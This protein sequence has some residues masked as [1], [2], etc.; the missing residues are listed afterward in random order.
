MKMREK[1]RLAEKTIEDMYEALDSACHRIYLLYRE[2]KVTDKV[3]TRAEDLDIW[4]KEARLGMKAYERWAEAN[5][6]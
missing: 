4:Y 1:L 6:D 3:L 2:V 5:D